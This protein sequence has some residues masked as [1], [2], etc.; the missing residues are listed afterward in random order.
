MSTISRTDL[1][2]LNICFIVFVIACISRSCT[3]STTT[4]IR[5]YNGETII[6]TR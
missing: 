6:E 4:V 2:I 5:T 1:Y 3:T